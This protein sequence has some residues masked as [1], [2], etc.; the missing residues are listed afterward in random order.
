MPIPVDRGHVKGLYPE[1]RVIRI[2]IPARWDGGEG[3]ADFKL[4]LGPC[5]QV[6]ERIEC[7]EGEHFLTVIQ[8]TDK[9]TK[10]FSY[11][12]TTLTGRVEVTKNR[13]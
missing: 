6:V 11:P 7:R 4:G 5:G 3:V 1:N 13:Y 10:T 8:H 12:Y 9:E 2:R